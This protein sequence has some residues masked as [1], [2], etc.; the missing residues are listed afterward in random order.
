MLITNK[1]IKEIEQMPSTVKVKIKT[2]I[3]D[4]HQKRM[5]QLIQ[6][7]N[8]KGDD[9][10]HQVAIFYHLNDFLKK[11]DNADFFKGKT[12]WPILY[13]YAP[14]QSL[15]S[16]D[17]AN[18]YLIS[19]RVKDL[20]VLA[21][22]R[23]RSTDYAPITEISTQL[24]KLPND[25]RIHVMK[26][27]LEQ[28]SLFMDH[29]D[30]A[31][32]SRLIEVVDHMMDLDVDANGS[33]LISNLQT[34]VSKVLSQPSMAIDEPQ[35]QALLRIMMACDFPGNGD[36]S[37]STFAHQIERLVGLDHMLNFVSLKTSETRQSH[38]FLELLKRRLNLAI[39]QT[40]GRIAENAFE[41]GVIGSEQSSAIW[42]ELKAYGV[43]DDAGCILSKFE[44]ITSNV[45]DALLN[46]SNKEHSTHVIKTLQQATLPDE[47]QVIK[48][49]RSMSVVE[50]L[51]APNAIDWLTTLHKSPGDF[52]A[53]C[54]KVI[55]DGTSQVKTQI[56]H[57][58][59]SFN[60]QRDHVAMMHDFLYQLQSHHK[61]KAFSLAEAIKP[62]FE[63]WS[64]FNHFKM[65]N[66]KKELTNLQKLV[67]QQL[68]QAHFRSLM[69][70]DDP[71]AT[72]F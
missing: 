56:N 58:V 32:V 2:I 21:V 23:P 60:D 27:L 19:E 5:D 71:L 63:S 4:S 68:G 11:S 55:I 41:L 1:T 48:Q 42:N 44:D 66:G 9:A 17:N 46:G 26:A 59:S 65:V 70:A 50:F 10:R 22:D 7:S 38:P 30:L 67:V 57:L 72:R 18:K 64:F 24:H 69:G 49:S 3:E 12:R 39:A 40:D 14:T 16:H 20:S 36:S 34:F 8:C 54:E 28:F 62:Q 6:L 25:S 31:S 53:F 52:N 33:S 47:L 61:T 29:D 37:F 35:K 51:S 43:L 45:N 15:M 13:K